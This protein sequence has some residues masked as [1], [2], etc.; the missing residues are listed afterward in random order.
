MVLSLF[1]FFF[2]SSLNKF[3]IANVIAPRMK[4]FEGMISIGDMMG[5]SYGKPGKIIT[6]IAGTLLLIG[7]LGSQ[8]SAIGYFISFFLDVSFFW[9]IIIGCGIIIIYSA[10]GGIKAVTITDVIQF[11]VLLIAIPMICNISL[12]TI[13]GY[14]ALYHSLPETHIRFIPEGESIWKYI[15]LILTFSTP[16]LNPAITQRLLMSKNTSQMASAMRISAYIEIPFYLMIS[17]IGFVAVSAYPDIS[18]AHSVPTLITEMLPVGLKGITIAGMMAVIMSTADSVLNAASVT[19]VHDVLKPSFKEKI[20]QKIEL[21]IAKLVSIIFGLLSVVMA[22]SFE[23]VVDIIL[24]SFSV[25]GPVTVIPLYAV[26]FGVKAD[27]KIFVRSVVAGL[28]CFILWRSLQLESIF[29]FDALVPSML[30]NGFVFFLSVLSTRKRDEDSLFSEGLNHK[31]FVKKSFLKPSRSLFFW[32]GYKAFFSSRINHKILHAIEERVDGVKPPYITF[33]VFAL[34]NYIVP[35]FMWTMSKPD[36]FMLYFRSFAGVLAVALILKNYWPPKAD[37][38]L[39]LFWQMTLLFCLPFLAT[40]ATLVNQAEIW[41]IVN[42]CLSIFILGTLTDWESFLWIL[43][44]GTGAGYIFAHSQFPIVLDLDTNA[45]YPSVYILV[46]SIVAGLI[47][48]RRR[49]SLQVERQQTLKVAGGAIAHEMR[50]PLA[51]VSI[52]GQIIKKKLE[53]LKENLFAN[54]QNHN[55]KE[56]LLALDQTADDLIRISKRSQNLINLLLTNLKQELD[57]LPQGVFSIRENLEYVL[58][59]F[60]YRPHEEEKV[61]LNIESDFLVTGNQDIVMHVFFNLLKNSFYFIQACGK[62]EVFISLKSEKKK[63]II[64]FKDTGPGIEKHRL[65]KIFTPFY[66]RRPHGTGVGLSFC[67]RAVE[68]MGGNN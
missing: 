3:I 1:L 58:K 24:N 27:S 10:F 30:A 42:L 57:D 33:G 51:N 64:T 45:F 54:S 46:V 35:H 60:A 23:S 15:G 16:F 14:E 41:W 20:T 21:K 55:V 2:G 9:S 19:F 38:Y 49:E 34:I 53:R 40:Y 47:F 43:C 18:A 8:I 32:E 28:S 59:E 62:G 11:G 61:H 12:N 52:N 5:H 29:G 17:I 63:N 26:I 31:S 39:S 13:G 48:S 44:L 4:K 36:D 68:S 25:W 66:S 6:G 67:K 7:T 65:S 50:T 56:Y 37:K 22:L